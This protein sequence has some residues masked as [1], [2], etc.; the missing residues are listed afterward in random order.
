MTCL[1]VYSAMKKLRLFV[2]SM[3]WMVL[4]TA[5]GG[6]QKIAPELLSRMAANPNDY[7]EVIIDLADQLDT[8]ALLL[9]FETN[10]T[11]LDERGYEV[12]T[13]LQA[14]AAATQPALLRRLENLPGADASN[15]LAVWIVNQIFV[16]ANAAAIQEIASWPEVGMLYW[17]APMEMDP[18]VRSEPAAFSTPNGSEPGLRAIK[19][20]FMWN[21][22]YTGYGRK[23]LII[24]TGD[25][26][27]HPALISNF[28]GHNVIIGQAWS[29]GGQP[30]DCAEHGT[31]VTG[32]VCGLDRKTND[33][34]GVA[35]NSRW[36]GGPME[37]PVGNDLG[38]QVNFS[39][40]IRTNTA[41]MQW[42]LNPDSNL[43]TMNDRPD[44]INC[45]W[46]GS[47]F[48][49]GVSSAVNILNALEAA[50][51]G[52]VWAQGNNGPAASTVASGAAMN[53]DLVNTFAVGAINGANSS[54]PIADF[55]SRGP[56]PCG[57]SGA[58]QIKP[59]VCAPGVNV[60]SSV[61]GGGYTGLDG[62]SMAAPHASGALLL[63]KEAFPNLSGIQLKLALYNSA[64]DLGVTGEDNA[65][66]R[67]IIDLEA[68]YNL[69]ISQGQVPVAP[70]SAERDVHVL[71]VRVAGLCK[72]PVTA[73]V[74]FENSSAQTINSLKFIYG[75]VGGTQF[76]FDWSGTLTPNTFTTITLPGATGIQP[77]TH[78]FLVEA[79]NPNGQPDPRPL[80]NV[81]RRR[82]VMAND[83]F[84]TAQISPQQPA[85]ACSGAR[86]LLEYTGDLQAAEV[87]KWYNSPSAINAIAEGNTYL[88]PPLSAN[89]TYYVS[90]S[91]L[92][93]T[94]KPELPT[95]VTASNTI[96]GGLI[97][98][99][100]QPF[101][102][103]SVK[104]YAD[105]P[106]G[107][108]IQLFDNAGNQI[109]FKLATVNAGETVV[110][111]NFNVPQGTSMRLTVGSGK[112]LKGT[113]S[114][115]GYPYNVPGVL[116]I[117]SGFTSAGLST[118]L[119]YLYFFDWKVEVPLVCGRTAIPVAVAASPAAPTV[120]FSA[121]QDP[122]YISNGGV[123]NFT[124]LTPG[125]VSRLWDFGN[126]TSSTEANPS[127]TYTT[128][129]VYTVRLLVTT[130]NGCSNATT[131]TITVLQT[132]SA[133]DPTAAPESVL[134]F[135]NPAKDEINL[136]FLQN[137]P[138]NVEARVTDL[139]G[140][141]TR[142]QAP[143]ESP[144]ELYRVDVAGLPPGVYIVQLRAE[145]RLYW[146]GKFVKE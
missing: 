136:G 70:A 54:F 143:V 104:V 27:D 133:N 79:V 55:S 16:N 123:A 71:D 95:G 43:S 105:E 2:C 26:A 81:F 11:P 21:L 15:L 53:M 35:F 10:Q 78:V 110:V 45:S 137:P 140:R 114:Q 74:T 47:P 68:A 61:P 84:P 83:D 113:S 57:G 42:A 86:V 46:R 66:G 13:R 24:D 25:D 20:P 112:P 139:L 120:S 30:E 5:Q 37:F 34:I 98:D 41:T 29:G 3:I 73:T 76:E 49:C 48:D 22:G 132:V 1:T 56:T 91:G 144:G 50:G 97:F 40:T 18:P 119:S 69:L 118:I 103:R 89:A 121:A 44:V 127:V 108:L 90:T 88:T 96:N 116:R 80:N 77:G 59:E 12:V 109:A 17:N 67:G 145:G 122:V 130:A 60:R 115:P 7:Q 4:A 31:H 82:F 87:V 62:T 64:K 106:G 135:P 134:L 128:P 94:G 85:T 33:T 6:A 146:T 19:A 117:F 14:K 129:G 32:T 39:Q 124:D 107:R 9:E 125:V 92:Y 142:N 65:Y 126:G 36:M 99:A 38:C 28:W 72:G 102:L 101:I 52:V 58:L 8:R 93:N 138:R 131:G 51:I 141:V 75:I 63:L 111:L 100:F 23:G